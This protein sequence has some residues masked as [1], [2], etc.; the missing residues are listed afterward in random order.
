[1][2]KENDCS[3]EDEQARLQINE[4]LRDQEYRRGVPRN[5]GNAMAPSI[6]RTRAVNS[7]RLGPVLAVTSVKESESPSHRSMHVRT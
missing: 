5:S 1:M 4:S 2:P 3:N 7:T 6:C